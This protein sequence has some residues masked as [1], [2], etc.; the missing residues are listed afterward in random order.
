[1]N[2]S[3]SKEWHEERKKG[4]GGSDAAAVLGLDPYRSP[5]EVYYEK[6][7]ELPPKN[8]NKHTR[9]GKLLEPVI[10]EM[11]AEDTGLKLRRQRFQKVHPEI[12]YLRVNLDRMII[13]VDDRGPGVLEIKAPTWRQAE[14]WADAC[15]DNVYLQV[16]HA[17]IV[18][19]WQWGYAC[20]WIGEG[21]LK[22]YE[23]ARNDEVIRAMLD[24]YADFWQCVLARTPPE[25]RISEEVL[26][27]L[28][29]TSTP[30]REITIEDPVGDALRRYYVANEAVKQFEKAKKEAA[31]EIKL[32][33]GDAEAGVYIGE[34]HNYAVTWKNQK[35]YYMWDTDALSKDPELVRK[36]KTKEVVK[37]PL[38]VKR[39][40]VARVGQQ[41]AAPEIEAENHL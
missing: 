15:P 36:Y 12:D 41:D 27:R 1:M 5:L 22:Y 3:H 26:A 34:M 17:M 19:G 18:T 6:T 11:F 14:K 20:A 29:P 35:P 21:D 2:L 33:M 13:S 4:I 24:K 37:R 28:Y 16:Q 25:G 23:I 7:G 40:E 32:A 31:E 9:R 10:A 38:Y 8:D 30:G 39:K